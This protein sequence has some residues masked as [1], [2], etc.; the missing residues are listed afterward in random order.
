MSQDKNINQT[1]VMANM[2]GQIGCVTGF[3]A[4][5][6]IGLAFLVGGW[7]DSL[8]GFENKIMTVVLMLGTFPVT[9]YAITRISLSMVAR[10]QR[11]VAAMEKENQES[12]NE[13]EK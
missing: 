13:E 10:A 5:I 9:L 2:V 6:I 12:L 8:L 3:V 4:L 11:R 7:L 1:I